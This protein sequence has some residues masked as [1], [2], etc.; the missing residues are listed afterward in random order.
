MTRFRLRMDLA[1][2]APFWRL[3]AR[4][5]RKTTHYLRVRGD[6]VTAVLD[7]PSATLY[8]DRANLGVVAGLWIGRYLHLWPGSSFTIEEVPT[9]PG[10]LPTE[11]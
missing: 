1:G 9:R 7:A 11:D 3:G 5:G 10:P 2:D 6:E 8:D 4:F